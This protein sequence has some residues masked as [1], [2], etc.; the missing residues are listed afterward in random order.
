MERGGEALMSNTVIARLDRA[1]QYAVTSDYLRDA[2][3]YWATRFRG[4]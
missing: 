1:T 2:L 4:W 3:E